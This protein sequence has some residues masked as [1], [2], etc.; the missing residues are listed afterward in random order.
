MTPLHRLEHMLDA[1]GIDTTGLE[2]APEYE[3]AEGETCY[4]D[5]AGV[6]YYLNGLILD[7]VEPEKP[8]AAEKATKPPA[9]EAEK[10]EDILPLLDEETLRKTDS[11]SLKKIIAEENDPK[12]QC[13]AFSVLK[14]RSEDVSDVV[15]YIDVIVL[16]RIE[17]S[18][19]ADGYDEKKIYAIWYFL[20]PA[21]A[22]HYGFQLEY[23][24]NETQDGELWIT[25]R[26]TFDGHRY[27]IYDSQRDDGYCS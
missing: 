15:S 8:H 19:T 11:E 6:L 14:E 3:R 27:T 12:L 13:F 2:R 7:I 22:A 18:R 24:E 16:P 20:Q 25:E 5:D 21:A 10:P 26:I 4:K 17:D 1:M 9:P 23:H